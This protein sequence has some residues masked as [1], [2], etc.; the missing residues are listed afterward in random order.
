MIFLRRIFG[1]SEALKAMFKLRRTFSTILEIALICSA[2]TFAVGCGSESDDTSDEPNNEQEQTGDDTSM[3]ADAGET[4]SSKDTMSGEDSSGSEDVESIGE[5]DDDPEAPGAQQKVVEAWPLVEKSAEN[6]VD[7][8]KSDGIYKGT[9]DASA[10]GRRNAPSNPF[11]YLD[12]E[13][14]SQVSITDIESFENADWD[15]A[16]RRI[17]IRTNSGDSGPGQISVAKKSDTSFEAVSEAPSDGFETDDTVVDGRV[18]KGPIGK[19]FTAFNYLNA[20]E[21]Q[22]QNWYQ[23]GGQG[24]GHSVSPIDGDIYIIKNGATSATYKF[25]IQNWA[26]GVFTVR[27]KAMSKSSQ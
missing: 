15:L 8:S 23:Y 20:G 2:L 13:T 5:V 9:V 1:T 26:D 24:G 25:E 6:K 7:I 17:A 18:K 12:L 3:T 19:P 4:S 27:W 22:A 11:V 10:G 14:G 21:N 16:F